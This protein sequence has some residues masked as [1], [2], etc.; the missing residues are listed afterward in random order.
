VNGGKILAL[1]LPVRISLMKGFFQPITSRSIVYGSVLY[2]SGNEGI[3]A[4]DLLI[5]TYI[6]EANKKPLFTELR[7]LTDLTEIQP[8]LSKQGFQ[9]EDH[10]NY[11]INLD[12]P[13]EAIFNSIGSRTRK[14]LRHSF[15]KES[16]I[17]EEINE[18][19]ELELCY[20]LI[21]QTYL[22]A[23]VPLADSSL[24]DAAFDILYPL[25]MIRFT[26]ARVNKSIASTSVEL[27]Y[28]KAIYGWYGGTDR[29]LSSY[30]PNEILTWNIL[31][32][33]AEN[34]FEL[35]DF[36]GAGKPGKKYGVRDFKAKFGGELVCYGRNT[37]VHKP[38]LF[39]LS[40][41]GYSIFRR[42]L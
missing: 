30:S 6:H 39:K 29:S 23:R 19:E 28:K 15:N 26:S 11:L 5:S 2:S 18:K 37:C 12:K 33:G 38:L 3:E 10:L 27:L 17:I 36:G 25:G 22:G 21:R 32:W 35:Y 42:F 9:Y 8:L 7:N 16:V 34:G 41:I 13:V 4:V 24:F 1:F 20:N 14:T 31:K 40:K